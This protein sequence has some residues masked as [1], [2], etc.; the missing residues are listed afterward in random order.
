MKKYGKYIP[1][2][3]ALV[4]LVAGRQWRADMT[5]DKRFTLSEASLRVTDRVKKPLEI[6]VYLKGDFPSYFRKLA[7][8]T[9]TLLEQFRVENPGI[10]YY[11]VNPI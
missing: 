11:F 3:L 1:L 4:L 2:L 9:R 10:H 5:R 7:E 8:E 6:K